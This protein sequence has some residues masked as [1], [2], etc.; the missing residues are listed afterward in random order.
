LNRDVRVALQYLRDM[1]EIQPGTTIGLDEFLQRADAQMHRVVNSCRRRSEVCADPSMVQVLQRQAA[2]LDGNIARLVSTT[3]D[4]ANGRPNQA[5][6]E[7]LRD[8]ATC[9]SQLNASVQQTSLKSA[10]SYEHEAVNR[11]LDQLRHA[12][13]QVC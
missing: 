11:L 4:V 1:K 8:V 6:L 2:A 12:I 10:A 7:A 9:I 3:R 13:D 5:H